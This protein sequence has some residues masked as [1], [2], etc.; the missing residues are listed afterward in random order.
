MRHSERMAD[1]SNA[2]R[3]SIFLRK[4]RAFETLPDAGADAIIALEH[5]RLRSA[6]A[7]TDIIREGEDPREV[8]LIVSGWACRYKMLEDG[9]RQIM[10]FF[11]PGDLC[12][13]H[14]YILKEMDHSIAAMTS[15]RFARISSRDLE[16]VGDAHPRVM[17]A[18]WWETLVSAAIQREWTVSVG[19]RDAY[20]ALAHLCCELYL[21]MRL[22][23]LAEKHKCACP[24]TQADFADA[25][26]IT[27]THA[28]RMIRKLNAS[29]HA[30]IARRTITMHNLPAL[31]A[32]AN[33]NPNYL[34]H[35]ND[36]V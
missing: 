18:L 3:E 29:G 6:P 8:F 12:D 32:V 34:H 4:L 35:Q 10:S 1:I 16:D 21:R 22:V 31:K 13:L 30:S 27:P 17:R 20:E 19:Q 15:L 25:L 2:D 28:G 24:L 5:Q 11:L 9:R 33:F 23:G 26:G 36:D 7:K 14:V